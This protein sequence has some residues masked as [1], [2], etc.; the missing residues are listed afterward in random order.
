[1]TGIFGGTWRKGRRGRA[2]SRSTLGAAASY[3]I[4][5]QRGLTSTGVT[6]VNGD[7]A[8]DPLATCTDSTGNAGASQSCAGQ[9]LRKPDGNDR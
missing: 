7:I 6:V 8:L 9:A 1:M 5:S 2:L 4:V 3:G